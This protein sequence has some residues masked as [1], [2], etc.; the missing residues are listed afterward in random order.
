MAAS[1]GWVVGHGLP[2][3]A[4][5]GRAILKDYCD[6]R[7]LACEWPPG[8]SGAERQR[9][10]LAVERRRRPVQPAGAAPD[11]GARADSI[12]GA[13]QAGR[14]PSDGTSSDYETDSEEDAEV[15]EPVQRA[16]GAEPRQ[17]NGAAEGVG[18]AGLQPGRPDSGGAL[19]LSMADLDLMDELKIGTGAA[20]NP[21]TERLFRAVR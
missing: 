2:D 10:R 16:D 4:R 18:A 6:G 5:A 11:A 15:L 21:A 7:L 9:A 17:A 3:E 1:R 14:G 12:Q 20:A 8:H 13:E 19:L